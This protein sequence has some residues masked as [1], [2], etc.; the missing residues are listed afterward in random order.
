MEKSGGDGLLPVHH[1]ESIKKCSSKSATLC[2]TVC[3]FKYL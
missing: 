2:Q 3:R 1:V